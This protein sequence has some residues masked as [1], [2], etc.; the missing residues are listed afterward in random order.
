MLTIETTERIRELVL[1]LCR[2]RGYSPDIQEKLIVRSLYLASLCAAKVAPEDI[3]RLDRRVMAVLK[4][5]GAVTRRELE[6]AEACAETPVIT[7]D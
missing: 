3:E 6:S 7:R 2:A 5:K 4:K 1:Q